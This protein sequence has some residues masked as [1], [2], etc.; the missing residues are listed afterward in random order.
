MNLGD[1]PLYSRISQVSRL[2]QV[3]V[4]LIRQWEEVFPFLCPQKSKGGHRLYTKEDIEVL[5]T[6]RRQLL[7]LQLTE[8]KVREMSMMASWSLELEKSSEELWKQA[9][10]TA[11]TVGKPRNSQV[12]N[13]MKSELLDIRKELLAV[14]DLLGH[15]ASDVGT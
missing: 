9:T 15:N 11:K 7:L 4:H 13:R 12:L 1:L 3:P 2:I 8:E 10:I 6:L 5:W 14:Y